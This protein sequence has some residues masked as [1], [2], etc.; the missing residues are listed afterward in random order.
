[1]ATRPKRYE[2]KLALDCV[3]IEDWFL[4]FEL[5]LVVQQLVVPPQLPDSENE[6]NRNARDNERTAM[7]ILR[8]AHFLTTVTP[9]MFV[10]TKSLMSPDMIQVKTYE[11]LKRAIIQ[12]LA[13]KPTVLAQRFAFYKTVQKQGEVAS[14]YIARLRKIAIECAFDNFQRALL[15]QF[16]CW[17]KNTE[18]QR[19]LLEAFSSDNLSHYH[20]L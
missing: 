10:L 12:H 17:L 4:Q 7:E 13:P 19:K 9:D 6:D 1:M 11:E 15:D 3:H 5:D 2:H 14:D 20:I 16:I 18:V 8:T